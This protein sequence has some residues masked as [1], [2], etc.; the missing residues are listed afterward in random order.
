MR[1]ETVVQGIFLHRPNRF[2]AHVALDGAETVVHV[3]NTGRCRE[4][5][6]PGCTVWLSPAANPARKTKYDLFAVEKALPG[7]GTRL[8]HMDSQAANDVATEW[9]RAKLP[10]ALIRREMR[11]GAS[12]FDFCIETEA[13]KGF[14]EVKGVTLEQDGVARFPDAPTERGVRHI[15]ELMDCRAAGF[16][17]AILF[18]VQMKG[19]RC[20]EPN[21]ATHPAFG[22]VLREAV[23][24][25]VRVLAV[26]CRTAP[27][28][29]AIDGQIPVIL[30]G[31]TDHARDI[32][33]CI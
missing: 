9:L 30:H 17:A 25:G 11:Y 23:A 2:I 5:L 19:V 16:G 15:R 26:D 33:E 18:V 8:I 7:G 31:G 6:V 20:L 27:D 13:G 29:I 10:N 32:T 24:A 22:A 1:Y 3:K 12:R 21:D 4:L 28:S 14:L